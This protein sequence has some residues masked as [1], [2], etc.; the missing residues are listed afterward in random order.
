MIT[1]YFDNNATTALAP[2]VLDAM[3]PYFSSGN[4]SSGHRLGIAAEQ[5][6]Q[7]ARQKL[8]QAFGS[9]DHEVIFTSGGTES[10]NLAVKGIARVLKRQGKHIITART[11]HKSV[12]ESMRQLEQEGFEIGYAQPDSRG[13]IPVEAVTSLLRDDTTLVAIMHVNNELGSINPIE[14]IASAIKSAHKNCRIFSDG[15][16]AFGKLIPPAPSNIDAYSMS[17][18]KFHGPKGIGALFLKKGTQCQPLISGGGQE[19]GF[20]SGSQNVPGIVG[21]V[22]ASEMAY[23]ALS[24]TRLHF[25]ALKNRLINGLQV[26]ENVAINSPEDGL[27]NTVNAS[28][29]NLP[30]EVMMRLLDEKG[31]CVSAGSACAG[32][33]RG[34]SHV[35]EA[36][37]LSDT[38]MRSA[39]R[40]SFSRYN[41]PDEIDACLQTIATI[42]SDV[43]AVVR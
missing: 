24:E 4:P 23:S 15:V 19:N 21:L 5:A 37:G 38:R 3:M 12:L 32:R 33:K 42:L 2:E 31:F 25:R 10:V 16:Q 28:F 17:G 43:R 34:T 6:I 13:C 40:F 29:I 35:L 9:R 18:H 8:L 39:I 30:S 27:A 41:T 20:R 11:E 14:N 7:S 1:H 22:T 26:L 36:I